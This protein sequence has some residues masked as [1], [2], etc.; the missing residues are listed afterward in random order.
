MNN[1]FYSEVHFHIR[2]FHICNV[3]DFHSLLCTVVILISVI[4]VTLIL[5]TDGSLYSKGRH[6]F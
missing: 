4:S 1:W 5:E 6:P 2:N 3:S